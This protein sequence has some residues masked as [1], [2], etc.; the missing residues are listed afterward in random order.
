MCLAESLRPR[1]QALPVWGMLSALK[2]SSREF[3]WFWPFGLGSML[4]NQN[5]MGMVPVCN[6]LPR[7]TLG[8]S[9]S[10]RVSQRTA[11]FLWVSLGLAGNRLDF[12]PEFCFSDRMFHRGWPRTTLTAGFVSVWAHTECLSEC[13]QWVFKRK[14]SIQTYILKLV[15]PP[16]QFCFKQGGH[17]SA[18]SVKVGG[19]WVVAFI[20]VTYTYTHTNPVSLT[21]HC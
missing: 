18:T 1:N 20:L 3:T 16:W 11:L 21:M 2:A 8:V 6:S 4:S 13:A 14:I 10:G 15:S 5:W 7:K 12:H 9:G 19:K 17:E